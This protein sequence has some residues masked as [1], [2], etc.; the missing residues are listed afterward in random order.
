MKLTGAIGAMTFGDSLY[1]YI[2]AR[3]LDRDSMQHSG[4]F[5]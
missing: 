1:V 4:L 2:P 5:G 3:H